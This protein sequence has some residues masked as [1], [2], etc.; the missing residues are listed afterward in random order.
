MVDFIPSFISSAFKV[1]YFEIY[2]D[3]IRDLLDGK[4]N[5][6]S[7]M[8]LFLAVN[9]IPFLNNLYETDLNYRKH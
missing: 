9:V 2:L 5:S 1:S 6:C 8:L 7:L 4:L 3:K